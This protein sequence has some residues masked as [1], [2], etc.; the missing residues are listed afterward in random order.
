[1]DALLSLF[2]LHYTNAC[3]KKRRYML[4]FAV[5]LCTE[6]ACMDVELVADKR[7]V[8]LAV[9]NINNIYEQIKKNEVKPGTDYLFSGL[10][11][12]QREFAKSMEKLNL[13][14]TL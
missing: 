2:S 6:Q 9:Q 10:N 12:R 11:D 3:A 5:S 8:E 7:K 1:M 13:M 14:N 4:Y